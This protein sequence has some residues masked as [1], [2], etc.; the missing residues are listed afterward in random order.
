MEA[1]GLPRKLA[2]EGIRRLM[3]LATSA[4]PLKECPSCSRMLEETASVESSTICPYCGSDLVDETATIAA[5]DSRW[6]AAAAET[7]LDPYP[8][9]E[10]VAGYRLERRL[11]QG[12]FGTVYLAVDERSGRRVALK[13]PRRERFAQEAAFRHYLQRFLAE[14]RRAARLTHPALVGVYEVGGDDG[15]GIPFIAMEHLEGGSLAS[16]MQDGAR[17]DRRA[18]AALIE[19]VALGVQHAHRLG[20]FHCDLKPSNIL[21][22]R[23]GRPK[24]SDF[25]LAVE[26]E[27]QEGQ[28]GQV[29]GTWPY[30]SPEQV[31]GKRHHLDGRTDVWSL[32]VV[33]YELLAGRRP[34]EGAPRQ[35]R[36]AILSR[37]V[38]PLA[39]REGHECQAFDTVVR[40]ALERRVEDRYASAEELGRALAR[41][42]RR[43]WCRAQARRA[44]SWCGLLVVTAL[45][46]VGSG[47]LWNAAG[48]RRERTS[49]ARF[50][51]DVAAPAG[52]RVP[53]F[54]HPL[55]EVVVFQ[56]VLPTWSQD[57]RHEWVR[58]QNERH[59]VLEAG[60]TYSGAYEVGVEIRHSVE[61]GEVGLCVGVE[62]TVDERGE[63][64]IWLQ[65]VGLMYHENH[66]CYLVRYL[67]RYGPLDEKLWLRQYDRVFA[68]PV[69]FP[70]VDEFHALRVR[71]IA[72]EIDAIFWRGQDYSEELVEPFRHNLRHPKAR[73]G[74]GLMTSRSAPFFRHGYF[75]NLER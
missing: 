72:D 66:Q 74:I 16:R 33:L 38:R 10:R 15:S 11:G 56:E 71:V 39:Q 17:L 27:E 43:D 50:Y 68:T 57:T 51:V 25:G 31:E 14:G 45:L 32:G 36:E 21:L 19:T 20:V 4:P 47:I 12:G 75:V 40:R 58:M 35:L 34:F 1:W 22:T 29:A 13:I 28:A 49:E 6:D 73:G 8:P 52:H 41:A 42:R 18:A 7:M 26:E 65:M 55:R 70:A 37:P 67:A 62:P 23:D 2:D 46:L 5:A 48:G 59:E 64:Q 24:V 69:S 63:R 9:L 61:P 44:A 30:M 60:V 53:L 3:V 54:D